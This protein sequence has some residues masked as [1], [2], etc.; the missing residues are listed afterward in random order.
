MFAVFLKWSI[1]VNDTTS[2]EHFCGAPEETWQRGGIA[3]VEHVSHYDDI[4]GEVW[5]GCK[6]IEVQRVVDVREIGC[7][8]VDNGDKLHIRVTGLPNDVRHR[9]SKRCDVLAGTARDLQHPTSAEITFEHV[10]DGPFVA[11]GGR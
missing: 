4:H 9:C 2:G 8:M 3:D 1:H 10:K 6:H 5:P 11:L 7:S